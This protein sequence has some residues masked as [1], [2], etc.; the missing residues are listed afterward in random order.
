MQNTTTLPTPLSPWRQFTK[1]WGTTIFIILAV[2]GITI[3]QYILNARVTEAVLASTIRQATPLVLGALCGLLGERSAVIN[4]GIEGQMLLGAFVGFLANV[5]TGNLL[6][7]V[8]AAILTG[9]LFGLLLA[10]MS[11]TLKMDQI[12]GGTVINILALGLTGYFY[13]VGLTTKGKLLPIP[14]GP[15]ADIPIIGPALFNNPPITYATFILVFVVHYVLFHTKWGLRTRAVGEH[16]RAADTLGVDVYKVRYVNV[17]L[18]GAIAGLAGAFLTLEAV[19]SFE[20]AMTNGRGFVALAVM[21]FGKFTPFGAWGAA[22]LFGFANAM[23]TQLQ[24]A[25]I[26]IAHQFI[27]MLPYVLTI[28]VLSGF[29]GRTHVP[30]ADG[31]PYDKE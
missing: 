28:V 30:A 13:Q 25:D 3:W 7:A 20:R 2:V 31:V 1:Q 15:L 6:F 23:Q 10:Y 16:P 27:G 12:I 17:I 11:V 9:A 26:K 8:F 29:V 19:G 24:F 18:G 5:W 22:L 14:L 4:I 21:I